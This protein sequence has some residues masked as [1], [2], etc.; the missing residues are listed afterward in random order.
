MS[1][2]THAISFRI[3]ADKLDKLERL[4]KATQRPRSWHVDQAL[5]AYLDVQSW[6]LEHIEKAITSIR[7]GRVVPHDKVRDWLLS[8]GKEDEVEPPI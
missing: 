7:Q 8:W 5:D 6:Q 1:K 3:S 2:P 4:A